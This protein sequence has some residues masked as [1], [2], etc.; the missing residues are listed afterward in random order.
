MGESSRSRQPQTWQIVYSGQWPKI[1]A[2]KLRERNTRET[3]PYHDVFTSCE[4]LNELNFHIYFIAKLTD[5]L[6]LLVTQTY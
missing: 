2:E 6:N 1:Y 5:N 4:Y 3:D